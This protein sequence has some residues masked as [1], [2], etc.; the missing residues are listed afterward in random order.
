MEIQK[1]DENIQQKNKTDYT[2]TYPSNVTGSYSEQGRGKCRWDQKA[3]WDVLR[4]FLMILMFGFFACYCGEV[5]QPAIQN[6][7][8]ATKLFSSTSSNT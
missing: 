8:N 5:F 2:D 7:Q 3:A 6:I 4:R 1:T